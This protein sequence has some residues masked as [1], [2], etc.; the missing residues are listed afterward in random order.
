MSGLGIHMS[1]NMSIFKHWFLAANAYNRLTVCGH[2]D[3]IIFA[4]V[5]EYIDEFIPSDEDQLEDTHMARDSDEEYYAEPAESGSDWEKSGKS[6]SKVMM[7][8]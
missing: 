8:F 7:Y 6:K 4:A 3:F 5:D 2:A 1:V